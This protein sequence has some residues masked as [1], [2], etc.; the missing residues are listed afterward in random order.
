MYDGNFE[1]VVSWVQFEQA[2]QQSFLKKGLQVIE[3]N[4]N[5]EENVA[6]HRELWNDVTREIIKHLNGVQ[7]EN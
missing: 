6:K 3:I 4:T 2:L 7:N 5:R 1:R